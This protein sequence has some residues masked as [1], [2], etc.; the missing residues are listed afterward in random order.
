MD[1]LVGK[2]VTSHVSSGIEYE[3]VFRDPPQALFDAIEF[4]CVMRLPIELDGDLVRIRTMD[5]SH[6]EPQQTYVYPSGK[7]QVIP[8]IRTVRVIAYGA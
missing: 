4:A 2:T 7:Y 5:V 1:S 8:T 6:D 3:F